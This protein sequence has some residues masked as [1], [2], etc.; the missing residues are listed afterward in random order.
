MDLM[1]DCLTN[2]Q[3]FRILTIVD[4]FTRECPAIEVDPSMSWAR[5]VR[6]LEHQ[7]FLGRG[8][9]KILEVEL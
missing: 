3:R 8:P 4:D 2:G 5:I 7:A 6:V 9:P 1:Q